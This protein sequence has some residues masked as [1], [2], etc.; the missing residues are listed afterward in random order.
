MKKELQDMKKI[1]VFTLQTQVRSAKYL[2]AVIV[3][4]AALFLIPVI[5]MFLAGRS[6][7]ESGS[8]SAQTAAGSVSQVY[9]VDETGLDLS[10]FEQIRTSGEENSDISWNTGASLEEAREMTRGTDD[11]LILLLEQENG[12]IQ[13]HLLIPD[14]S[15]LEQDDCQI[16]ESS[17]ESGFS[18]VLAASAGVDVRQAEVIQNPVQTEIV[19]DGNNPED[20]SGL[21]TVRE[22]LSSV[23]PYI[24]IMVLYFMVLIYGQKVA[25]SVIMEKSSKL[26]DTFLTSV[27]PVS[28][29]FG[30]VFAVVCSSILQFAVWVAGLLLG[31]FAGGRFAGMGEAGS[32]SGALQF[33]AGDGWFR[34]LFSLPGLLLA[35]LILVSGFLLYCAL[36]SIGGSAAGKPE[37]LSSTNVLFTTILV[38]SFLVSLAAGGVGLG[39]EEAAASWVYWIPFTSVLT[40][41]GRLMLGEVSPA[42]GAGALAVSVAATVIFLYLAAKIYKM[43]ALYKGNPPTPAK[44]FRMLRDR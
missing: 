1:F 28:M 37:D 20:A 15:S 12:D 39:S 2:A 36:A 18:A 32:A 7:S 23:L 13:M 11:A 30:K 6:A 38:V 25:N 26:M 44:L 3:V 42:L 31:L 9:V 24:F 8:A 16:L 33:L 4:S 19:S 35:V 5:G 41:P 27:K 17:L 29:I 34:E 22:I 43:M 21:G 14:E 40:L 10:G